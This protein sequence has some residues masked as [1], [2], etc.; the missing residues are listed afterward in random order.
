MEKKDRIVD[1][2]RILPWSLFL[3]RLWSGEII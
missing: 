2:I 1:G 3:E